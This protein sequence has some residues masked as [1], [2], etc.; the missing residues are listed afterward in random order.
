MSKKTKEDCCV[1]CGRDLGTEEHTPSCPNVTEPD[2]EA[3]EKLLKKKK[4]QELYES[5]HFV[6][7]DPTKGAIQIMLEIMLPP[8]E[9]RV[10]TAVFEYYAKQEQN[11]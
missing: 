4:Q 5:L 7:D 2:R 6:G 9:M 1:L 3:I 11:S 8:K 10:V